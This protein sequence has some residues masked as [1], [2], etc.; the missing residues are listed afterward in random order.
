MNST[1]TQSGQGYAKNSYI[2]YTFE[3]GVK[4]FITKFRARGI[5][6]ASTIAKDEYGDY[7]FVCRS[8]MYNNVK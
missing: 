7:V 4:K 6:N 3:N 5:D 1:T 2:A 8:N